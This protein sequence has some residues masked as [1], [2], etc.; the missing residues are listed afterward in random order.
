[1]YNDQ[2]KY[3][4]KDIDDKL[5]G[6]LSMFLPKFFASLYEDPKIVSLIIKNSKPSEIQRT[7]LPLF[8]NNFYENILSS[9]YIQ[10]NL[11]YVITLLY[12]LRAKDD[13]QIYIKKIIEEVVEQIDEYSYSICFDFEKIN[14]NI[15]DSFKDIKYE[16]INGDSMKHLSK[17]EILNEIVERKLGNKFKNLQKNTEFNKFK[18]YKS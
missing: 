6:R 1:M 8:G 9:K 11:M 7:L 18:R 3:E 5:L 10:N 4:L 14:E 12:E 13:T 2:R 17:N 15:T 16:I